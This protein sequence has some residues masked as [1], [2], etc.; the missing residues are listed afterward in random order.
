MPPLEAAAVLLPILI[1]QDVVGVWSFRHEWDGRIVAIMLS[2]GAIGVLLGYLFASSVPETVVLGALGAM[3]ILFAVQRLWAGR[4]GRIAASSRSPAWVGVL[5]GVATGFTSHIAHAGGPPFQMWVIPRNLPPARFVGTTAITF[6]AINW[7][8]V[9]AYLAAG[10]FSR[11]TLLVT[12]ALL[13]V[14][15]ASTFAGVW[16]VRRVSAQ[17]FYGIIYALLILVGLKLI[18]D[19]MR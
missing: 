6:A 9:P 3:S 14:A 2:G 1:V 4:G 18:V 11:S 17:R 19:A 5:F 13:P 15:I 12:T 8:K 10:Q 7:M 16:L